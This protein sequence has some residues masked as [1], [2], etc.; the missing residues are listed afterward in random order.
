MLARLSS[1]PK[2]ISWIR[3]W[4][5]EIRLEDENDRIRWIGWKMFMLCQPWKIV[6]GCPCMCAMSQCA[7]TVFPTNRCIAHAR[8]IVTTGCGVTHLHSLIWQRSVWRHPNFSCWVLSSTDKFLWLVTCYGCDTVPWTVG[9][10]ALSFKR[11]LL[12]V[13]VDVCLYVCMCV[14]V[15]EVKY[16][17]NQGS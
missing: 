16:L 14:R 11:P 4:W 1:I 15:F 9:S 17:G 10:R 8:R 2:Q 7:R 5:K 6:C 12:S 13:D 3:H